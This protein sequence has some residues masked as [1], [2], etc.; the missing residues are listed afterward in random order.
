MCGV[1]E[2]TVYKMDG[3]KTYVTADP[4]VCKETAYALNNGVDEIACPTDASRQKDDGYIVYKIVSYRCDTST[5]RVCS[6]EDGPWLC[7]YYQCPR[8]ICGKHCGGHG[9]GGTHLSTNVIRKYLGI[10]RL[11]KC[12]FCDFVYL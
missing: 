8:S 3:V 2:E 9:G 11:T 1:T 6:S 4:G 7:E 12:H 5:V 10:S